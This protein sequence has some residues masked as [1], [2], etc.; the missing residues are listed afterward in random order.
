[1][2]Y[3]MTQKY[4]ECQL[5]TAI[6]ASYYY[7]GP[8]VDNKLYELLVDLVGARHGSAINVKIAYRV[9]GLLPVKIPPFYWALRLSL[10]I[11]APVELPIWH[12]SSG[13]HSVLAVDAK[14]TK[15]KV[16]NTKAAPDGWIEW[17]ELRKLVKKGNLLNVGPCNGWF[18]AI[19]KIGDKVNARNIRN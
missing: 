11:G 1:M 16:L 12:K 9:L 17:R 10:W 15:V 18:R 4:G 6:N 5:V 2:E 8:R 7:G 14:G 19:R 3:L 13:F